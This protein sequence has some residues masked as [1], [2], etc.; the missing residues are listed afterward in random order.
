MKIRQLIAAGVFL[1]VLP[2]W[3]QL[4][5]IKTVPV[6][7]GDQF[8]MFPNRYAGMG[9]VSIALPDG[10]ADPFT[11]PNRGVFVDNTIVTVSPVYYRISDNNGS[12][13]TIP[14]AF[15]T[16]RDS[17][18]G[19]SF[20][21]AQDLD[22]TSGNGG[23]IRPTQLPPGNRLKD[24][25]LR[26]VYSA[27]YLGIPLERYGVTLSGS[28]FYGDL[29]GMDGVEL[30]YP[31]SSDIEQEGHFRDFRLGISRTFSE[32]RRLEALVLYHDFNMRHN[33]YYNAFWDED[34]W[35]NDVVNKHTDHSKTHGI[36]FG[37][38]Q[39]VGENDW[40]MGAIA[41]LNRKSHPKIPN[42]ELMNIPRDPGDTWAYNLGIG[43]SREKDDT[44]F[45]ID[46]IYEPIW[47][48][49]WADAVT[50][51]STRTGRIIAPGEKTV[52]NEFTFSNAL[53]KF[54]IT[55]GPNG[56]GFQV[57]LQAHG[58]QYWLDQYDY[59]DESR[60]KQHEQWT[61]WKLSWG[62]FH[63]YDHFELRYLGRM[64]VGT[65]R[66]GV[67]IT[68]SSVMSESAAMNDILLAPDGALT[69]TETP[70][71]THQLVLIIPL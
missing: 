35:R 58:Y 67:D 56:R 12:A 6:S 68:A 13:R 46:L 4:I 9:G 71:F 3:S 45:G 62:Y 40:M 15:Q 50:P 70:I 29:G 54:G 51:V 37:Y 44:I 38:T 57:G 42:Y 66:P 59:V 24:Q 18:Y 22:I 47:S 48:T 55:H 14:L 69:L 21:S 27:V 17:W 26:N 36:H 61:E 8:T 28:M 25:S 5:S 60:R 1:S 10:L 41:T 64:I 65:G 33:V 39:P 19:G 63:E 2:V 16:N 32:N 53:I 7:T 23:G 43:F 49:T 52:E 31:N 11:N 34:F 20:V 30:L